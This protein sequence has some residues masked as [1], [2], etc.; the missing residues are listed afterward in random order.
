M[1]FY[2]PKFWDKKKPNLLALILLP[3]TIPLLANNLLRNFFKAKKSIDIIKICIGNIYV[4]GTGKTP[5]V[6]YLSNLLKKKGYKTAIISRGYKRN[7]TGTV[8]VSDGIKVLSKW[9]DV[10]DEPYMMAKKLK[11][12]PIVVDENRFRG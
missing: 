1:K 4:G 5:I 10:G 11:N 9:E 6:I 12:I 2:K 8:L 3:L 7:T